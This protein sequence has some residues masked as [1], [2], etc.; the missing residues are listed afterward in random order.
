MEILIQNNQFYFRGKTLTLPVLDSIL[1]TSNKALEDDLDT[2]ANRLSEVDNGQH[3]WAT[4]WVP[5]RLD[6]LQGV[7]L[8]YF[9]VEVIEYLKVEQ[10]IDDIIIRGEIE[11]YFVKFLN[12]A[13]PHIK[14]KRKLSKL[15]FRNIFSNSIGPLKYIFKGCLK[16]KQIQKIKGKIWLSSPI[17][18]EKHRYRHL[19][20]SLTSSKVFYAGRLDRGIKTKEMGESMDFS[21]YITWRDVFH[22]F[23]KALVL[24]TVKTKIQPSTIIDFAVKDI[25]F[26]QLVATIL[27]EKSVENAIQEHQPEQIWFTT[28]N[29]YPP[30]RIISRLAY[31]NNI[32]FVVIACRPMFTKARLE[33]RLIKA[34]RNKY[35]DAHVANAYAVWDEYSR[36][37]LIGQGVNPGSIYVTSPEISH[38]VV[39]NSSKMKLENTLLLLFTHEETLNQK[40]I[41][42]LVQLH[43]GKDVVLRQHPLKPLTTS[44]LTQ[45]KNKFNIIKDITSK[46]YANFE[47][48][49]TLAI[50]VNSTAIIEAVS[51]GCGAVWLPYLN[52]RSLLFFEIMTQLGVIIERIDDLESLL[53][54]SNNEIDEIIVDC[55]KTYIRKFSSKDQTF[56]FLEQMKLI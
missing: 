41:D 5:L 44:Q 40:F 18:V 43:S 12:K 13:Y 42:E 52:S 47:F 33:E 24:N 49:N 38:M 4:T 27:K 53:Q 56:E 54:L 39:N 28:A 21:S 30:A 17:N 22:S 45:L 51:H 10:N 25:K 32:P 26:Q 35:N 6:D 15:Y 31:L 8:Y 23:K 1:K 34:D 55:Q 16:R 3:L 29:T 20:S 19:V 48:I 36:Q 50:T 37:T 46:D 2:I 11:P 14:V 7:G 9:I